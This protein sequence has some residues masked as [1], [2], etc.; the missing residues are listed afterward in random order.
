LKAHPHPFLQVPFALPNIAL[1]SKGHFS[2]WHFQ[3]GLCQLEGETEE[4]KE[5]GEGGASG[6]WEGQSRLHLHQR[7][8]KAQKVKEEDENGEAIHKRM[9]HMEY[10]HEMRLISV[11]MMGVIFHQN[12][13]HV[14]ID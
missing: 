7:L 2:N 10:K 8:V 3:K 14:P 1:A 13:L 9:V 12:N 11:G 6:W 5:A 4:A